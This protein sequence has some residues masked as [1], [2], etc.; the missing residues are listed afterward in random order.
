MMPELSQTD[1][2]KANIQTLQKQIL[3]SHPQ[4]PTLLREI[5][6]QLK[7]D[8]ATVTLLAEEEIAV[9]VKGLELQTN[10]FIAASM[11]KPK[12]AAKLRH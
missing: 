1:L 7:E 9:V 6:R 3:D 12:A 4:M 8:P 5:H 2:I 11:T 10:T